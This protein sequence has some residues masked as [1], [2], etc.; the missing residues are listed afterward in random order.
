MIKY[1]E[2]FLFDDVP[3]VVSGGACEEATLAPVFNSD[4][5]EY[6]RNGKPL[7]KEQ[8]IQAIIMDQMETDGDFHV[9]VCHWNTGKW[10]V[11]IW[12]DD[13]G[14]FKILN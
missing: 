12:E 6:E 10:G 3:M 11:W 5:K 13:F 9:I 1:H 7:T 4:K 8:Y 2:F 14:D